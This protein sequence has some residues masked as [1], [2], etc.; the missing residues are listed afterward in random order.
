VLGLTAFFS[1][2]M[3]D[4]AFLLAP[5]FVTFFLGMFLRKTSVLDDH[6]ADVLFK[7]VYHLTLPALL[8][9]VLPYV[10]ISTTMFF[11][12]LISAIIILLTLA[13]AILAGKALG[14][15][16]KSLAVLVSGSIIMNLGFVMPFIQ[17]FYGDDGLARLF[18]FDIPNGL[19]A[20]TIAYSFAGR[21]GDTAEI[22]PWR[23]LIT[24][25]PL[26]ALIA[27]LL[28][29]AFGLHPL[30]IATA[31]LHSI[32]GLT[33]PLILLGLGASFRIAKINPLYLA[34]AIAL[35]MCLGLA[36]GVWLA[37]LFHLEGLDRTIVILSASAPA[38]FNTMTFASV[39]KL[40]REFAATLV[41]SCIIASMILIPLLLT[42]L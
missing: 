20:C 4:L 5:A 27:A 39:E 18:V 25:P 32:G 21:C 15:Q 37:G 33:I 12:P 6:A 2:L 10:A 24:S 22:S 40:D 28:M 14:M 35:R 1:P 34:A 30:P 41:A 36:L 11:L 3:F 16:K 31:V 29:N 23:K 38:G 7:L 19:S 13:A 8:L 17:S 42:I 26:I 9:S